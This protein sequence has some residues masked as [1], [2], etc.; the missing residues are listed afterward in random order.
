LENDTKNWRFVLTE[1]L[2]WASAPAKLDLV[3]PKNNRVKIMPWDWIDLQFRLP[4]NLPAPPSGYKLNLVLEASGGKP[5]EMI[6][7]EQFEF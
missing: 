7:R 4:S 6:V 1:K 3:Q 5:A 2:T